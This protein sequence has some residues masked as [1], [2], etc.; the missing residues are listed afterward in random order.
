MSNKKKWRFWVSNLN[1]D[2]GK[3]ANS[4][5]ILAKHIEELLALGVA[6]EDIGVSLEWRDGE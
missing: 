6:L 4:P 3:H 1:T 5:E 2:Q